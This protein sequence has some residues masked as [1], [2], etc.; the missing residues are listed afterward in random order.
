M[1]K[2]IF[3]A[4]AVFVGF[5]FLS[6]SDVFGG[7]ETDGIAFT[8]PPLVPQSVSSHARAASGVSE[9]QWSIYGFLF[10][11]DADPA[12]IKNIGNG[13][14]S[15]PSEGEAQRYKGLIQAVSRKGADL[16]RPQPLFFQRVQA[17]TKC[18]VCVLVTYT[19]SA[20]TE[21]TVFSGISPDSLV[22]WAGTNYYF[23]D[24]FYTPGTGEN[25]I[26][27]TLKKNE[28]APVYFA[29]QNG[30]GV[31]NSYG[32]STYSPQQST[33]YKPTHFYG[34][35]SGNMTGALGAVKGLG[36]DEAGVIILMDD[37][38]V[39]GVPLS[40]STSDNGLKHSVDFASISGKRCK[41]KAKDFSVSSGRPLSFTDVRIEGTVSPTSSA[42]VDVNTGGE[43][44]L[45]GSVTLEDETKIQLRAARS[46][47][48]Q[49]GKIVIVRPLVDEVGKVIVEY[50]DSSPTEEEIKK[51]AKADMQRYPILRD[52]TGTNTQVPD[53]F[54]DEVEIVCTPSLS[55]T[56]SWKR[57]NGNWWGLDDD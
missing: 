5:A 50:R 1:K 16:S 29:T 27:L 51:H 57:M 42:L 8:V 20:K 54:D 38:D 11:E 43:L 40:I 34:S 30:A 7:R 37:I 28:N 13:Q 10:G 53:F 19:N 2:A 33:P 32:Q 47:P 39:S 56:A 36:P 21:H 15:P 24:N 41:L 9:G 17:K 46:S 12:E 44:R 55:F 25:D 45:G 18:F 49:N 31:I 48:G 22:N 6:C 35:Y 14:F 23:T 52:D 3:A 4:A 26:S